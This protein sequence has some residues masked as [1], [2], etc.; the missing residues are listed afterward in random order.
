M[1]LHS[2]DDERGN[3]SI[4]DLSI[5]IR[6]FTKY[7]VGLYEASS[8]VLGMTYYFMLL[9]APTFAWQSSGRTY[10]RLNIVCGVDHSF[11]RVRNVDLYN[12]KISGLVNLVSCEMF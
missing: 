6:T 12:I 3:L 10:V 1:H 2:D 8:Y 4:S 11:A 7:H 9:E 5:F